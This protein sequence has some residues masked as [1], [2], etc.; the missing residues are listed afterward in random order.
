MSKHKNI[1]E[2]VGRVTKP[3]TVATSKAGKPWC[4]VYVDVE[5]FKG[6]TQRVQVVVF[7][8]LAEQVGRDVQEGDTV[9]AMGRAQASAWKSREGEPMASLELIAEIVT[10]VGDEA[11]SKSAADDDS[12]PF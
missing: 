5:G 11:P 10:K 2:V 8:E 9:Q 4:K 1:L 6:N 7:G 3:V 12:L